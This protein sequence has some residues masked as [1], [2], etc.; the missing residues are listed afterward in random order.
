MS[1]IIVIATSAGGLGPLKQIVEALPSTCRASVF[2]VQHIGMRQSI[3]PDILAQR[4][5]LPTAFAR[6]GEAIERGRIYVAPPDH[7]M[8][9]R[10][11]SIWLDRGVKVQFARPAA[12]PLFISAA[13]AYGERVVGIVL[14]GA[15]ND[16][17]DGLRS[18]TAHGGLGLVQDPDEA[19]YPAMPLAAVR[20]DHPEPPLTAIR[21]A[22]RVAAHCAAR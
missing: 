12:D 22:E 8:R 18:I 11:G 15:N 7:H 16:G 2:I 20:R 3:L 10:F 1:A 14:S 13:E 6:Q 17:A 5:N 9:L 19:E 21:L 4:G